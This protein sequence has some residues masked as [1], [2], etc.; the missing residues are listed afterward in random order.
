MEDRRGLYAFLGVLVGFKIWTL[1]IILWLTSTWQTV[2]FLLAGHVLWLAGAAVLVAGPA[3]FW[4]RL[5]RVRAKRK[6]LQHAEWNV[7]ETRDHLS[8]RL[9]DD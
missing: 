4:T 5:I 8:E 6:K 1:I 3:A 7:E 2:V 9:F